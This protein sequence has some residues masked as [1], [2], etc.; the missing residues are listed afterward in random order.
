[1]WS[2]QTLQHTQMS[3]VESEV[4]M[5]VVLKEAACLQFTTPGLF[6]PR[7]LSLLLFKNTSPLRLH[8]RS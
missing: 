2:L 5:F 4:V 7:F 6:S 1:M 3:P 8:V